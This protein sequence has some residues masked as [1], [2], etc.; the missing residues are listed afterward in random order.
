MSPITAETHEPSTTPT[1]G[2]FPLGPDK[3]PEEF[4]EEVRRGM[5]SAIRRI[6]EKF[7]ATH[8]MGA[9]EHIVPGE[10]PATPRDSDTE[11]QPQPAGVPL[12]RSK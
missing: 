7:L 10:A 9:E 1:T 12:R 6:R 3:D 4:A 11:P 2:W 8:F 5:E